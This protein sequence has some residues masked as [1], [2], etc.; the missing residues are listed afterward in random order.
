MIYLYRLI[1]IYVLIHCYILNSNILEAKIVLSDKQ[2][3]F[4]AN[5]VDYNFKENF[6]VATGNVEFKS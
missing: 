4:Q 3:D 6:L 2:L 5:N 1:L